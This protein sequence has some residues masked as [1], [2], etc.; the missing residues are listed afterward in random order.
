MGLF[1]QDWPCGRMIFLAA[2]AEEN[3]NAADSDSHSPAL[4]V[5]QEMASQCSHQVKGKDRAARDREPKMRGRNGNRGHSNLRHLTHPLSI[6]PV[7]AH[8]VPQ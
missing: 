8:F 6:F 7:K 1:P 2:A 3:I 5:A 4:S